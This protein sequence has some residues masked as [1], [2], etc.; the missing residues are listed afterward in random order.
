MSFLCS[1]PFADQMFLLTVFV[2]LSRMHWIK[3]SQLEG[4]MWAL[5]CFIWR[6]L[7]MRFKI[8]SP[9]AKLSKALTT[10]MMECHRANPSLTRFHAHCHSTIH[11][12]MATPAT[13]FR[14][15]ILSCHRQIRKSLLSNGVGE[16]K[17]RELNRVCNWRQR[18]IDKM[19]VPPCLATG[20]TKTYK[21]TYAS[22]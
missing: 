20:G 22:H 9:N 3:Q 16:W 13:F 15:T 5:V 21:R 1:F 2:F 11:F 12:S 14:F 8:N 7:C 4:W 18:E 17:K 6:M 19:N 10:F